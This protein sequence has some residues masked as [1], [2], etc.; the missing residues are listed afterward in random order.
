MTQTQPGTQLPVNV[1]NARLV[2]ATQE[3]IHFTLSAGKILVVGRED[4]ASGNY[5]DIDLDRYD[6]HQQGVGRRHLELYLEGGQVYLHELQAV[7]FTA[8]NGQDIPRD[9]RRPLNNGDELR[10]GKMRLHYYTS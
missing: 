1:V 6:G 9:A 5:P 3:E 4:V 7:N 10:L 2:T 8:I